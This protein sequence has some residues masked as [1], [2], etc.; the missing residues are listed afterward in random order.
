MT[1][2]D[3]VDPAPSRRMSLRLF[4]IR[5]ER[6]RVRYD[7]GGRQWTLTGACGTVWVVGQTLAGSP[8]E[9]HPA[10]GIGDT[11]RARKPQQVV[12]APSFALAVL[13]QLVGELVDRLVGVPAR[14]RLAQRRPPPAELFDVAGEQE[15]VGTGAG[16]LWQRRER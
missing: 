16:H 7:V 4:K 1:P 13:D 11:A 8:V 5:D 9:R 10:C 3:D 2:V 15:Q 14:H 6:Q 12:M